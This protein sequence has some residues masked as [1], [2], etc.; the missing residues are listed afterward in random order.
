LQHRLRLATRNVADFDAC[1]LSLIDPWA[2]SSPAPFAAP[3][4]EWP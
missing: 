2:A 1:G 4:V 3:A